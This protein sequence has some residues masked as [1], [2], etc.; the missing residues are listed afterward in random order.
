MIYSKNRERIIQ[1]QSPLI[2]LGIKMQN[3]PI[4]GNIITNGFTEYCNQF[5]YDHDTLSKIE[6]YANTYHIYPDDIKECEGTVSR[7]ECWN[8]FRTLND[9]FIRHRNN[10]P[11]IRQTRGE[12]VSPVDAYTA[13]VTRPKFWIKGSQYTTAKL[14]KGED[15]YYLDLALFIFRL[16][17]HHYHRI[18]CPVYG[19]VTKISTFGNEYNSV[20]VSMVKS[21]KNVLTHNVRVVIEIQTLKFGK[22]YL[23]C[24]GATC[25]GSIVIHHHRIL[26]ALNL[27]IPFTDSQIR[28]QSIIFPI[29]NAPIVKVN[30]ELA[31]FQ[32][33]GSCVVL[34]VSPN[35]NILLSPISEIILEYTLEQAETEIEVG[36]SLLMSRK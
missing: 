8:R 9:F 10:L 16:A 14:M 23:A 35:P 1:P 28:E 34:G 6:Q 3:L 11:T 17:P 7:E 26:K 22:I 5:R 36:D 27:N 25:V 4:F 21:R 18:H 32:Y 20:D 15:K 12:L 31:Y 13:F 2:K 33:G 29:E 19:R 24:I 30:E